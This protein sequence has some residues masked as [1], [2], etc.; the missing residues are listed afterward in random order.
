MIVPWRNK[1]WKNLHC[2]FEWKSKLQGDLKKKIGDILLISV[3]FQPS[4][5]SALKFYLTS[6]ST[7][8]L[9]LQMGKEECSWIQLKP[10]LMTFLQSF[11]HLVSALPRGVFAL[12]RGKKS[13]NEFPSG[14]AGRMWWLLIQKKQMSGGR[15]SLSASPPLWHYLTHQEKGDDQIQLPIL[16]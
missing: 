16:S 11:G 5:T 8:V 9:S 6:K 2:L 7:L 4:R 12:N 15:V 10:V 3:L 13:V 1:L 14:R